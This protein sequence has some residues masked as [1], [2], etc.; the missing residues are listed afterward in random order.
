M[1]FIDKV[2]GFLGNTPVV[3]YAIGLALILVVFFL[4]R[5]F[6]TTPLFNPNTM[7][8]TTEGFMG[9]VY[10]AGEPPCLRNLNEAAQVLAALD[11]AGAV[12]V[13]APG[14]EVEADRKELALLLGKLACLKQDLMSPSGIVL[15]TRSLPFETQHDRQSVAEVAGQCLNR[16]I[17]NRDLDIIFQT[18]ANR[19]K[20]LIANLCTA[21]GLDEE[22]C[23]QIEITF[24]NAWKDVYG[25]AQQRCL[26]TPGDGT[27]SKDR[28]AAFLPPSLDLLH[29][30]QGYY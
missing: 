3:Y 7:P 28:T 19:G 4:S 21:K 27:G 16:S 2:Q 18:W 17:P 8:A 9:T 12:R 13:E 20:Q 5:L 6:I 14:S 26:A 10:G 22:A 1:D 30:Y 25:V 24:S 29:T 15:A 11:S 23:R